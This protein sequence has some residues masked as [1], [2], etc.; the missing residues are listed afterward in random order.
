MSKPIPFQKLIEVENDVIDHFNHVNNLVYI[1]WVLEIS[2]EHWNAVSP[3]EIRNKFGWMILKHEVDYR[4]Q[5]KL[6]DKLLL[7]TWIDEYSTATSIRK[8]TIV[9]SKTDQLI[10]ESKAKW[11]FVNLSTR[12]PSRLSNDIV[13]PYFETP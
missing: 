9:N 3:K 4:K 8:T 7:K 11:C 1:K 10:F 12:K 13:N 6:N 2:K 5:A